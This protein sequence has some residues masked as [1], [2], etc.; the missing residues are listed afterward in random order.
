MPAADN[1]TQLLLDWSSGDKAALD[2]LMPLVYG[3]LRQ[4]AHHY[5]R[6]ERADHTLQ[7]TAL[8]HEAYLRLISQNRV[9]WQNRAHFFAIS[10]QMMRRILIDHARSHQQAKRGGGAVKLP[11]AE[12]AILSNEQAAEMIA[13]DDALSALEK[14]DSR[15]SR[16][17]E[18]KF[19][20]GLTTQE[21]A[22]V[23]HLSPRTIE[24]DWQVAQ[25]W[26]Y[27]EMSANL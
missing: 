1:V 16:V 10:A 15:K 3:E 24:S 11:L 23:L 14:F 27:R 19:F 4:L 9:N 2:K 6:A 26:L 17:V 20:G 21:I 7:T 12:A 8:V 25:A 13:L 18:L 5:L 22:E